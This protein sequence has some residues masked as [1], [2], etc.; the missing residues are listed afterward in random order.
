MPDS[1]QNQNTT[2]PDNAAAPR[3]GTSARTEVMQKWSKFTSAEVTALKDKGDLI[4]Q[5][6]AKYSFEK[7]QAQS[8]V[9]AFAKGRQL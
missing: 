6:Q 5:V 4:A 8:D 9:D 7:S 1:T 2:A 3:T